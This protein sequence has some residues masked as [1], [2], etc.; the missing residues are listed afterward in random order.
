[1]VKADKKSVQL[2]LRLIKSVSGRLKRHQACV[3][4]LGLRRIGQ[5]VLV[6]DTPSVRGMVNHVNY[7]VEVMEESAE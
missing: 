2:R 7:L 5:E 3:R 4:G 6:A 1:M